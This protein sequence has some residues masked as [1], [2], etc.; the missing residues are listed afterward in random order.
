MVHALFEY[1]GIALGVALYRRARL[2]S[3]LGGLT[4]PGG[5]AV[6]AGL[7]IGAAIGNKLVFLIERPD[8]WQRL[9]AGELAMP[10]QSIVGGLLGGLIGVEIAKALTGQTR[11]TGDA[12]VWPI[13]VG[14]AFGRIGCF[15]AG[16]HDDTYG[17]ATTLPWGVDFG[18]G[19]SRHPTQLYDA[20]VALGL[21]AAVHGR[22]QRVPGLR[23]KLF[24][25]GYL[26]WRFGIDGLEA[27]AACLRLRLERHPVG[28]RGRARGVCAD[29]AS[30]T[31]NVSSTPARRSCRMSR[32]TRPYL[33]YDTTQSVCTTCLRQIEAK[34]VIKDEQVFMDKW[35]PAHGT[36]RVLV[37]DDAAYYRLGREVFVKPPEMP[38][39]L[40]HPHDTRLPVRLRPVP[41]PH[42]ARLPER[43]G[44]HRPLQPALPDLLCRLGPG[45]PDAPLDGRGAR[46]A[47][48][49]D[50][51]RRRGRR[52]AALRRR[53]DAAPAVLRR[54]S[55]RRA[56][57]RSAT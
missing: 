24:L 9:L 50:S 16:L 34:I 28:V 46:D 31:G 53:A 42:A 5:F 45:T 18:D 1:G 12:M 7:L 44:D 52:G 37:A 10:G 17:V 48:C 54:S 27:G 47:R 4:Q 21:A 55:P 23:F 6:V 35:C 41:R 11:S 29:R 49:G 32:K 51:Q 14:L 56:R 20:I 40:R 25:S 43:G 13:A 8:V 36:E 30:R 2:R 33:F 19:V 22:L 26:L 39:P 3:G 15:I 38:R 57:G